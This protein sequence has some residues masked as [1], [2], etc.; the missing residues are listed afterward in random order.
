MR[1][2]I[3]IHALILISFLSKGQEFK[4]YR[5]DDSVQVSIPPTFQKKDTLG[6]HIISAGTQFGNILIIKTP[7]DPKRTPEIEKKSHLD[8]FYE[9]YVKNISSSVEGSIISGERDT[10][11]N[12]LRYKDFT[13]QADSGGGKQY[14]NFRIVHV[15]S[16][17]YIFQFL[18]QDVHKEYAASNIKSFFDGI[19]IP[20]DA[21]VASQF[22]EPENTTGTPPT[23]SNYSMIGWGVGILI[24]IVLIIFF[25]RRRK[26]LH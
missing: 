12:N 1:S 25:I 20:P 18:Y 5:I 11:I 24:L 3:L 6:Q 23:G 21:T 4:P 26:R 2:L 10:T 19:K 22:T 14:R 17:T 15:N 8:A 9:N 7:D 16:A 13:L